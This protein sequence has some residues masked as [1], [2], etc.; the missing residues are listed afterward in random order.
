MAKRKDD[1]RRPTLFDDVHIRNVLEYNGQQR[2]ARML[3][4]QHMPPDKV[5]AM[6]DRQVNDKLDYLYSVVARRGEQLLLVRR[7][8]LEALEELLVILNRW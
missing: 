4:M 3:L 2:D 6:T 7:D 8:K 5:G 1:I